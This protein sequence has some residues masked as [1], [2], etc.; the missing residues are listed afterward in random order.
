MPI[1]QRIYS[2]EEITLKR[3]AAQSGQGAEWMS[4][5]DDVVPKR[6]NEIFI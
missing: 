6:T 3:F 4:F 5:Q 2:L 1:T